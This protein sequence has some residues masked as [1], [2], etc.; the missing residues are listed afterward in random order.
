VFLPGS[1][2]ADIT[3]STKHNFVLVKHLFIAFDF[4]H[5]FELL[6]DEFGTW[7]EIYEVQTRCFEFSRTEC[8]FNDP[9]CV[10]QILRH[11]II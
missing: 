3:R 8:K 7:N 10:F 5:L 6:V 11:F 2:D 4:E 1:A 9:V